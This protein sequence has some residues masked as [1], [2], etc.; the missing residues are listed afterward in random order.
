MTNFMT[1]DELFQKASPEPKS[2]LDEK[3]VSISDQVGI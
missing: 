2:I 1:S 3:L